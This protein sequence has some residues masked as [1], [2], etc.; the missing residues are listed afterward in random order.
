MPS[1][2]RT[3]R[4]CARLAIALLA[5]LPM[6]CESVPVGPSLANVKFTGP[7]GAAIETRAGWLASQLPT[8]LS[9]GSSTQRDPTVCCCQV[10]GTVT[11]SN[12]VPVHVVIQFAAIDVNGKESARILSFTQD[13]QA[14]ST[15]A[16]PDDLS[17][18]LPSGGACPGTAGFL[19]SC[20]DIDHVNYQLN[21]SSL[22]PPL[23]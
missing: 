13:L 4:R 15:Y 2:S 11:N 14:N 8:V 7:N 5:V 21:V 1:P 16:I 18:R 23:I 20:S 3:R 17:C 19:L 10:R 12:T 22:A 9:V 6:S